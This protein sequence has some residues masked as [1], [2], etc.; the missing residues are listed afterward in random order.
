MPHAPAVDPPPS[1]PPA[2][3][4]RRPLDRY[5]TP[6][7]LCAAVVE[8]LGLPRGLRV[9]EPSVGSG[10]FVGPLLAAGADLWANDIDPAAAGLELVPPA[11]RSVGRFEEL[12]GGPFDLVVMNPPFSAI[13]AHLARAMALAPRVVLV[14]R[15]TWM[16]AAGRRAVLAQMPPRR[17]WL[18]TPRPSF[19]AG[20]GLDSAPAAVIEWA[21][22][23]PAETGCGLLDWGE[24]AAQPGHPVEAALEA[25]QRAAAV[26][27]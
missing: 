5:D 19:V 3:A 4:Q 26:P 11:R 13:D 25:W 10:H 16:V 22:G 27:R 7:G 17:V 14:C 18:P 23:A 8:A 9:L 20:G 2:R 21:Q 15:S 24:R 6:R 1:A 12:E